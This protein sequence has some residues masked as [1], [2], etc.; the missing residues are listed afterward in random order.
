MAEIGDPQFTI[1]AGHE[2]AVAYTLKIRSGCEGGG[3]G[4]LIQ[5]DK[6]ATLSTLNDQYLFQ[7]I[8]I[9]GEVAGTLDA[10][11]FK[12]CGMRQGVE[13]EVVAIPIHD[14]ATRFSGKRGD[15][16]DGKGNG[17]GVG[18]TG[19]PM[20]TLTSGDRHAVAYTMQA[21]GEYKDCGVASGLKARDYKDATDLVA[22]VCGTFQ[23]TGI[24]WWNETPIGATVRTPCGGD[25][26]LANVCVEKHNIRYIV[27][28]LTPTECARLQGFADRWGDIDVKDDFTEE[29]YRFWLEVRNT[30]AAING[31]KVQDYTKAQMVT[32]YNRLHTDSSEYKMW[33]NG[34]ALPP[35]LYCMQGMMDAFCGMR[36]E[37]PE[38]TEVTKVEIDTSEELI[39][40]KQLPI[41]EER[42]RAAKDYVDATVESAMSLVC[43]EETVQSVKA[44]RADLN[45]QFADLEEKR[46]AVKS[47]VLAPYQ[48]FEAVYKEC[49]S[50]AFKK[51]DADLKKKINDVEGEMKR[52]CEDAL[53]D[54]FAELCAVNH[55]DF[56]PYE[57]AGI[58]V[59]MADAKAKTQPPKKLKEQ[60]SEFVSGIVQGM[61][62]IAS[63]D[64]VEEIM[65]EFR[66]SLDA[67]RSI[68]IVQARHKRIEEEKAARAAREEAKARET[69]VVKKVESFAPPVAAPVAPK[70][71]RVTFTVTDTIDRLKIL[72]K[73]LVDNGYKYE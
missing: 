25:S 17:L 23:N 67:A 28:R 45:K 58:T 49:V 18:E 41:I 8:G 38:M 69:E 35:A 60:L 59:S 32:W 53:R 46:K 24:G 37:N 50:D 13:R 64:C 26:T 57:R 48:Q 68:S 19:D 1:S 65:V 51:A 44:T 4:A 9:N 10:S 42:L 54:Y 34:I 3:K 36:K 31:K 73:F 63:M 6:S 22:E 72:K 43:T 21:F 56:V 2:H 14:Q 29:E 40:V 47:S 15:K 55:I 70:V 52:R 62:L 27:R 71:G 12:G 20:N 30:H 5:T 11:Y 39:K 66:Q 16:S 33:G 7:P 61:E